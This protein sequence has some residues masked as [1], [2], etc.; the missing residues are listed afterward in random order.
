MSTIINFCKMNNTKSNIAFFALIL[1]LFLPF[2]SLGQPAQ[3]VLDKYEPLNY[4]YNYKLVPTELAYRLMRPI[5]FDASKKY[6]VI[7][8]LYGG[9]A[10][11][12]PQSPRYNIYSLQEYM[13][14]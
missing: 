9:T 2:R 11:R 14:N 6:P 3:W 4:L 10:F 13:N 8:T 5:N 7:V 12:L 1:M